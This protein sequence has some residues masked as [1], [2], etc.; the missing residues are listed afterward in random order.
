[1]FFS[2]QIIIVTLFA[3]K[4]KLKKEFKAGVT[5]YSW[6]NREI[7][8]DLKKIPNYTESALCTGFS[9]KINK[10]KTKVMVCNK[11]ENK[12]LNIRISNEKTQKTES[13]IIYKVKLQKMKRI[14]RI[15]RIE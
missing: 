11:C 9:I 8:T 14:V 12:E 3:I 6:R 4:I 5:N 7:F 2:V 15:V 10:G 1:M 13:S